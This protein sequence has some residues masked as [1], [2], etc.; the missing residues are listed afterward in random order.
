MA[1]P[2]LNSSSL[3]ATAAVDVLTPANTTEATLTSAVPSGHTYITLSMIVVNN[4]AAGVG[5]T[6]N[7]YDGSNNHRLAVVTS[8]PPS[9]QLEVAPTRKLLLEGWSVKVTSAAGSSPLE[10]QHHYL[11]CH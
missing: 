5:A 11:D 10:F 4:S 7:W 9:A 8:V 3:T 1:A 2:N 6:V